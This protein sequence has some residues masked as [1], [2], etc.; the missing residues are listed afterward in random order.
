MQTTEEILADIKS[1]KIQGATNVALAILKFLSET[2]GATKETGETLAYARPTEPL[3]Q[4]AIRYI[5]SGSTG[6]L[7]EKIASYTTMIEDAKK[8]T[9]SEGVSLIQDGKTYLT[10]CHAST[11]T[12]LFL[13]AHTSGK[14]F[15]VIATETR[16]HMQGHLTVRELL[17]GGIEDVTM[18]IDAAAA[19]VLADPKRNIAGVFVGSDLLS[20]QG[21]VNKIGTL[22]IVLAAKSQNIPVYC[23]STLLKYDPRP[24][25]Q[26]L[27][28]TRDPNE[29]WPEAPS[30]LSIY[31][32]IFDYTP[33]NLGVTFVTEAGILQGDKIKETFQQ[34]YGKSI[35]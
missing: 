8:K 3:A 19:S 12:N 17:D 11:V 5:F 26:S 30:N 15:R 18:I 31:S 9:A 23:I 7:Q 22:A 20:E 33:Y 2:P 27:I 25:N 13:N 28:E 35:Q 24:F 29:V 32:P 21:F 14:T 6:S 16:P 34:Y 1:L 10:H 4:N